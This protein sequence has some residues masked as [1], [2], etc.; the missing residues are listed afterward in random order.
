[1]SF[2]INLLPG[3]NL[4][5]GQ[6]GRVSKVYDHNWRAEDVVQETWDGQGE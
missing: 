2:M 1:M 4:L 5:G 6:I 3:G